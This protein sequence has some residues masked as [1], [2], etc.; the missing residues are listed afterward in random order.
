[1]HNIYNKGLNKNTLSQGDILEPSLLKD[2]LYGHQDYFANS[3]HFYK[4]MVLTQT[5]DLT[6]IDKMPPFI[7]LSVVRKLNETLDVKEIYKKKKDATKRLLQELYNY[8]YNKRGFFY[9][10]KSDENGIEEESLVDLRVIFSLHKVHY[11]ALIKARIGG[12][13]P[14]FASQLGF[15]VGYMFNRV[16]V[17]SWNDSNENETLEKKISITMTDIENRVAERL[18]RLKNELQNVCAFVGC[19]NKASSYRWLPNKDGKYKEYL[20]C[21]RHIEYYENE[22]V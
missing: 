1:M 7:F 18:N 13:D 5:C 15:M 2:N 19:E 22:L 8:N 16:A 17:P 4:Y 10:P 20:L 6:H 14:L 21:D 9:L 3:P 11:K 12:L